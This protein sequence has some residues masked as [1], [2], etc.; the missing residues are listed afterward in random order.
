MGVPVGTAAEAGLD[1][2]QEIEVKIMKLDV[3]SNIHG[4]EEASIAVVS[5]IELR[6]ESAWDEVMDKMNGKEGTDPLF[7]VTVTMLRPWGVIVRTDSGLLGCI[8]NRDLASE[9]GNFSLMGQTMTVECIKADREQTVPG[10]PMISM[11][12][13]LQFSFK[14]VANRELCGRVEV[15]DVLDA[16]VMEIGPTFL[17]VQVESNIIRMRKTDIS[18][19]LKFDMEALFKIDEIIK[20][21]VLTKLEK[22][23]E[24]RLSCRALEF[25]RGAMVREKELV[26]ERAEETAAKYKKASRKEEDTLL[27]SLQQTLGQAASPPTKKKKAK[28]GSIMDESDDD[29]IF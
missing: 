27:S 20:T 12:Y 19:M 17:M 14:N 11:S 6:K 26:F 9:A 4:D 22:S 5:I 3:E 7:E 24:I 2:G 25:K 16:K 23:G 28:T 8:T 21:Y 13:P 18:S 29:N 15:G 10:N 1:I